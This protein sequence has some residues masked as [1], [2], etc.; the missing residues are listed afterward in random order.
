MKFRLRP[1]LVVW[2][3]WFGLLAAIWLI[4]M[5][6]TGSII[7]FYGEADTALNPETRTVSTTQQGY[8]PL[9]DVVSSAENDV[10][11]S[12]ASFIDFPEDPERSLTILLRAKPGEESEVRGA[13]EVFLDP[14]R[15]EVLGYRDQGRPEL[16]KNF[17]MGI[18]YQLHIDLLLG[19]P[20]VIFL[21]VVSFFWFLDH[22]VALILSF[23]TLAKWKNSFMVRGSRRGHKFN[24][25]L[26]RASG[27]WLFPITMML[28]FSGVYL[29]LYEPVVHVVEVFSPITPR[30]VWRTPE[31]E[32]PVFEPQ[33]SFEQ[34]SDIAT[35]YTGEGLDMVHYFPG[36]GVYQFRA[37][38][39]ELDMDGMGRRYII[40]DATSGDIL[41]DAHANAGTGGDKFVLWQ[42]A[43]HSGRA[44]GWTGR[45]IIFLS[46]IA[47]TAL[48][49]T[50]ILIWWK[51]KKARSS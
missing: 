24:F 30:Y 19:T 4:L 13:L 34:A 48:C 16:N 36:H 38:S 10:P 9:D 44:F 5:A 3:R 25:R 47:V 8:A 29:N 17:I 51:K 6:V 35:D 14:Y 18:L 28:S 50:G 26:H 31:L 39:E 27:I 32:Q 2:H 42:Y 7:V 1:T 15:A 21:G 23:P 43:L 45:I 40:V 33:V 20:M 46:G 41:D 49:V 12:Y 11:G 37:F 22:F